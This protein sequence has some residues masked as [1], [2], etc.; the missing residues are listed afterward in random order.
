MM[1]W[2]ATRACKHYR[3]GNG[4]RFTSNFQTAQAIV[5]EHG[6]RAL[7]GVEVHS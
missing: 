7:Q 5:K 3:M 4:V 1:G 6:A 2:C